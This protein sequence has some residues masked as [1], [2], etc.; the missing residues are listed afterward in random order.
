MKIKILLMFIFLVVV[1]QAQEFKPYKIKSGKISY[2]KLKYS[3]VSGYSNINGVE[4]SYSKQ[5]AIIFI[6]N[7]DEIDAKY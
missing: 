4:T 1:V 3:T 5:V 7:M 2:E 6:R